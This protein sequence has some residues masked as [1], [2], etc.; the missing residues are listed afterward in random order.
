MAGKITAEEKAKLK[1]QGFLPQRDGEH[2][3]VRVI[4]KDGT[5]SARQAAK[6]ARIAETY[7]RGYLSYTT[8][9]T[10]EIPWIRFDDIAKV[11]EELAE[12]DLASGGTG[13]RVRPV[14]ACKGTVCVFGLYDT[15]ELAREIHDRFYTG[16]YDVRLPHKFKIGIGG[17]PNNCI[18]PNLNDFGIMGQRMPNYD[19]DMCGGCKVCGVVAACRVGAAKLADGKLNIDADKCNGCGLCVDRCHFDAVEAGESGYRLFIGGKWGKTSRHGQ[20]ITGIHGKDAMLSILEKAILYYRE[21]GKTGERFGDLVD[22]VGFGEV[23]AALLGDAILDRKADILN[24]QLHE[25]KGGY[26][27]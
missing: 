25:N 23:E 18:K 1:G 12:V 17:C 3:A 26:S 14:V 9:L 22:R 2:F 10:V 6:L 27:C 16:Y 11:K 20:P 8:R 19:E 7:G 24:A 13:P 4:T 15:Q 5:S 21:A